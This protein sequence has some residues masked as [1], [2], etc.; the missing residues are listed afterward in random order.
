MNTSLDARRAQIS[1]L[2]AVL[3]LVIVAQANARDTYLPPGKPDAEALLPAPPAANSAEQAADLAE[4]VAAYKACS[5]EDK[6]RAEA[7]EKKIGIANFAG[8]IGAS[9]QPDKLPKTAAL[10]DEVLIE[11]EQVVGGCK[12]HWQRPRP[13]QIDPLDLHHTEKKPSYGYP[14]GH[15]TRATVMALLLAEMFPEK[16]DAILA[17]G[18][19]I[20]WDRVMLGRHYETDIFAGRVLGQAIVRQLHGNPAFELDFAAAKAEINSA[21][22]EANTAK[23]ELN[24][25]HAEVTEAPK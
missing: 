8:A 14:S 4:T 10:F 12:D 3:L 20:G 18:R 21:A 22:G 23:A 2:L 9:F 7:E 13:Y 15:S 5:P 25:A 16:R 1:C 17:E 24:A 11:S 19:Q 6:A